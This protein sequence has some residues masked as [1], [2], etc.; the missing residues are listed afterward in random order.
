[1]IEGVALSIKLSA[2]VASPRFDMF[3]AVRASAV[4]YELNAS[5]VSAVSAGFMASLAVPYRICVN[6]VFRAFARR[7]AT[8]SP[9]VHRIEARATVGAAVFA[10]FLLQ[11]ADV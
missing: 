11:L 6:I 3:T 10:T 5:A 4:D 1:M 9:F 2:V 8:L 7:V